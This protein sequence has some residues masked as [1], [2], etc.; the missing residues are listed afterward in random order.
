M[1][2][3][4]S[5]LHHLCSAA[6]VSRRL[7]SAVSARA[8]FWL[9]IVRGCSCFYC[10]TPSCLYSILPLSLTLVSSQSHCRR[11]IICQSRRCHLNVS[12]P[13]LV[14]SSPATEATSGVVA[15]FVAFHVVVVA[16]RFLVSDPCPLRVT[17][18]RGLLIEWRH[19][20]KACEVKHPA[21]PNHP[22]FT[23]TTTRRP[24]VPGG[25]VPEDFM[26]SE[27][28]LNGEDKLKGTNRLHFLPS[29]RWKW[30]D[31]MISTC[32][33]GNSTILCLNQ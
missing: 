13:S 32:L 17:V 10:S 12:R 3:R 4:V 27:D 1:S 16:R 5:P 14:S 18:D 23:L 29:L 19:D 21:P 2:A 15:F 20:D 22:Y 9:L 30:L 24:R 7:P 33:D 28:Y 11:L 31:S 26:N 6:R 8:A 25:I